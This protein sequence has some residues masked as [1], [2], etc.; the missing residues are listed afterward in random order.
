MYADLAPRWAE[1]GF[2][3]EEARTRLALGRCLVALGRDAR[4]ELDRARD[5]LEALGARPMLEEAESLLA[6]AASRAG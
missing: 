4:A 6:G 3:L 2:G 1:Y 5:L